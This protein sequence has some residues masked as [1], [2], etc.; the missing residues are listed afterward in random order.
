MINPILSPNKYLIST[1]EEKDFLLSLLN[2][3]LQGKL[4]ANYPLDMILHN[5]YIHSY[6]TKFLPD[7]KI[8]TGMP[9]INLF[10]FK[11]FT[12]GTNSF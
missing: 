4:S 10:F 7:K 3:K 6:N 5:P 2:W 1:S 9:K 8:N 11:M 12:V